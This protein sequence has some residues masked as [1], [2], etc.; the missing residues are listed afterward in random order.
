MQL[1]A[2]INRARTEISLEPVVANQ[3]VGG[4]MYIYELIVDVNLYVGR[5]SLRAYFGVDK[6]TI[7]DKELLFVETLND[8]YTRYKCKIPNELYKKVQTLKLVE[9]S[10]LLMDMDEGGKTILVAPSYFF[11]VQPNALNYEET[12]TPEEEEQF[13]SS[14]AAEKAQLRSK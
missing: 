2:T 12:M 1:K 6:Q 5:E 10:L 13:N 4:S 14:L 9:L 7:A 8:G 3:M 11:T